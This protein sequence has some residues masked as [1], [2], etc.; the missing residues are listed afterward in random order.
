MKRNPDKKNI[1]LI[2]MLLLVLVSCDRNRIFEENRVVEKGIWNSA[3]KILFET[4]ISDTT[5]RYNIYLNIRNSMQYP[6]SNLYLFMDTRFPDGK[7]ARDTVDCL[8][9]DYDG[10]WLGSGVGSVKYNRFLFQRGVLFHKAGRYGFEFQQA[11]RVNDLAGIHDVGI[12][13]EKEATR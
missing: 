12:R 10:R 7:I 8:L 2:V 13:I 3:N 5:I 6:Y 9:A 1:L 4:T 11:M